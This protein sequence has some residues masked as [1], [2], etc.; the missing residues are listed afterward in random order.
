MAFLI[1]VLIAAPAKNQVPEVGQFL[2]AGDT[3]AALGLLKEIGTH[4][5]NHEEAKSLVSLIRNR[6]F[7]KPPEVME[8][9]FLALQGIGSRKVTRPVL[10]LLD[11][12]TL[13]KDTTVRVGV[14]RALSGSADPKAVEPLIDLMRDREDAVVAAAGEAAGAFRYNKESIRKDL[15]KTILGIYESTWN[16]KNSVNPDLKKERSRAE[17]KWEIIEAPMERSLQL[18]SN[19]TQNS[20][21]EWRRWWNKNKKKK[22]AELEN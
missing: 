14:C 2:K 21:P 8:A 11:H 16:L 7:K 3:K 4:K 9:C 20:P 19:I 6:K 15:F 18:L 5:K 10:A 1:A 12:S 13:K 22:W 17:R